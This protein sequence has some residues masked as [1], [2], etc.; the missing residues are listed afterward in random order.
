MEQQLIQVH[1]KGT[2]THYGYNGLGRRVT[3]QGTENSQV[4]FWQ[5]NHLTAEASSAT[6]LP[7][8]ASVYDLQAPHQRKQRIKQLLPTIR[9]YVYLPGSYQPLALITEETDNR[10]SYWYEC[11]PNGAPIRL[12]DTQSTLVWHQQ[13]G[14][15]GEP[16]PQRA[17]TVKTRCAFR[18][19]ITIKRAV[20]ITT[21]I[22]IMIRT[23]RRL[24]VRIR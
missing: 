2:V 3:K 18:G 9:E 23:P 1:Q 15:W 22:G 19:S 20:Y 4:F 24:S 7:E 13:H 21:V 8:S 6:P 12:I 17:N 14:V 5:R 10:T 11:D 16:G